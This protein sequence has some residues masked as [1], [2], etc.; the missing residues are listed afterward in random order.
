M[1][2]ALLI[3]HVMEASRVTLA[4][5]VLMVCS[6]IEGCAKKFSGIKPNSL[7]EDAVSSRTVARGPAG[8]H[9]PML[10]KGTL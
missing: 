9:C 3:V 2:R 4:C 6:E 8:E 1:S 10:A 7:G 5:R